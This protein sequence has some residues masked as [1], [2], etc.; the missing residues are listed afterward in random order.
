MPVPSAASPDRPA[1]AARR[2]R[3][4]LLAAVG[5]AA[6]LTLLALIWH[7]TRARPVVPDPQGLAALLDQFNRAGAEH[8]DPAYCADCHAEATEAWR[9]SHHALANAPL[10]EADRERLPGPAPWPAGRDINWRAGDP[11][12][13]LLEA[14]LPP[15]PAVG[16][17]GITPLIQYL[18][19][20]P[21]GRIQTH[22]VAWDVA[23]DEWF[24]VFERDYDDAGTPG[25]WGHWTGQGMNWNANC[26]YCHMTEFHKNY[27]V[28]TNR[29]SSEWSH[30]AITCAQCHPGMDTHL[31]QVRNG[32]NAFREQLGAVQHMHTCA[33][34]HSLRQELTPDP[35]IPGER[36]EDRYQLVLADRE[37]LYH[38]DGQV[39][40]EN[41]V[42]GS[43][44]LS[45]MGHAGV[46]CMDCHEPHSGGFILPVDN[47]ALCQRCHSG[48]L[49]NAPKIHPTRHSRHPE[50]STG[51]QC[52]ECHMPVS[53][54]M[55]RDGRRDH[56]FSIP[57]P[58]LTAEMG[59]PNAC[60][61]CHNTQSNEWSRRHAEEWY[62]PDMNRERRARARLI[63]AVRE[64]RPDAGE[65]L[66]AAIAAEPNRFWKATFLALLPQAPPHRASWNLLL[67]ALDD[68]DPLLRATAVN[69]LGT[70]SL[71]AQLLDRLLSD[72]VR[73]VRI[74]TANATAT[75]DSL[76]PPVAREFLAYLEHNADYP[77]GA[78]RLASWKAQS[79]ERAQAARLARHAATL[80]PS[81]AEAQRLAAI[82]LAGMG[83]SDEALQLLERGLSLEPANAVLHFNAGLLLAE[84]NQP[85]RARQF[86]R[87][88]VE[89]DP[90]LEPAWYNLA[91]LAW[92]S[93][94]LTEAAAII[95]ESLEHLP[96]SP[97]LRQ[98]EQQ[99]PR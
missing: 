1:R 67:Q 45:K 68:P 50:G 63:T 56:S 84:L 92:R 48:G 24:S 12:P 75:S 53:F 85:Q 77:I 11:A 59:I 69:T 41:Y 95:R 27:D 89:H 23:R 55:A 37:G 57:D 64:A 36:Y 79:G 91:V 16:T 61:N 5:A 34:C 21:D 98:L 26:A 3:V 38:P 14:G 18:L 19:M 13:V 65:R 4:I 46:T 30:M 39:I 31:S 32:N 6:G 81:S 66:R 25:E 71:P 88:A 17:I 52:V 10:A 73:S 8:A 33:S 42:Y 47:N 97:R 70:D 29:Y 15:H 76:P 9:G 51:N 90:R 86:L 72:P 96:D 78:L 40:G 7:S 22:D 87:R 83:Q 82:Q 99:L 35:F 54:F 2:R 20:A 94:N 44:M 49:M 62:G 74:A 60:A 93:G 58:V 80:D 43:L 28:A